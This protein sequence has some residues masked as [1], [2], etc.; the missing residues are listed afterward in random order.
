[1][2]ARALV[3]WAKLQ[4]PILLQIFVLPHIKAMSHVNLHLSTL[5]TYGSVHVVGP[6]GDQHVVVTSVSPT[7]EIPWDPEGSQDVT[8]TL[9]ILGGVWKD[10]PSNVSHKCSFL[11]YSV[12]ASISTPMCHWDL[13]WLKSLV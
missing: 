2:H 6:K 10:A 13:R 12:H 5:L 1:M 4:S 9:E 8:I 11:I 7:R 3:S